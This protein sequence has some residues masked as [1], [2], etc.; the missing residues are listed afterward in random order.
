MSEVRK[1]YRQLALLHHPDK[2]RNDKS[3][4]K[5]KEIAEAY[6]FLLRN[7]YIYDAG[8]LNSDVSQFWAKLIKV[9][10]RSRWMEDDS[11]CFEC[12]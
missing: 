5:F 9:E 7:K 4:D 6:E 2:L 8:L 10:K 3:D 12:E 1:A 11:V